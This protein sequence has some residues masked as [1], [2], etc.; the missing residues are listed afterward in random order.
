MK[1]IKNPEYG[2][3]E[4]DNKIFCDSLQVS[5]EL[6]KDE[7]SNKQYLFNPKTG[8]SIEI[9]QNKPKYLQLVK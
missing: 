2:L 7:V 4:K 9:K 1:L 3:Y 8:R 6:C 5:E